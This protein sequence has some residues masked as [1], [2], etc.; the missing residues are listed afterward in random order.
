MGSRPV[1]VTTQAKPQESEAG[2]PDPHA[3]HAW[4][5]LRLSPE[6]P[7]RFLCR[8]RLLCQAPAP[9]RPEGGSGPPGSPCAALSG[10]PVAA[11]VGPTGGPCSCKGSVL[12]VVSEL[13]TPW[14]RW[15]GS[16][17]KCC[18]TRMC[19]P[20]TGLRSETTECLTSQKFSPVRPSLPGCRN[21]GCQNPQ[22]PLT[23]A[24]G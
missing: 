15:V 12:Y 10:P 24:E 17:Y 16:T 23:E 5:R 18:F 19:L 2:R 3:C 13:K 4:G 1:N 20:I 22:R 6:Q 11:S 21:L 14:P 9:G 7:G 8:R